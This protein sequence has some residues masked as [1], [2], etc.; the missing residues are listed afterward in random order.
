MRHIEPYDQSKFRR[1]PQQ[2]LLRFKPKGATPPEE[3]LL[4]KDFSESSQ[5]KPLSSD[6]N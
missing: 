1:R 6:D 3:I 5:L 4:A 2:R